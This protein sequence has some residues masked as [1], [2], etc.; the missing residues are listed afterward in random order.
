MSWLLQLL[1]FVALIAIPLTGAYAASRYPEDAYQAI[2]RGRKN[3]ILL[4]L[5][6]NPIGLTSL[7]FLTL[8]RPRLEETRRRKID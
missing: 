5:L 7:Y 1:L 8:V 4:Q 2:G 3:W 6:L